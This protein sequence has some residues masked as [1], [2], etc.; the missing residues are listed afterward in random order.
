MNKILYQ[1]LDCFVFVYLDNIIV[2]NTNLKE[3]AQHLW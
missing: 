3:H 2:Y 1:F